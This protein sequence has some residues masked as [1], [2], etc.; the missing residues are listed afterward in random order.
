MG[1][2]WIIWAGYRKF[3]TVFGAMSA[4][5]VISIRPSGD[6]STATSKNTTGLDMVED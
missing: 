1:I 4:A 2:L 6:P 5:K 3:S